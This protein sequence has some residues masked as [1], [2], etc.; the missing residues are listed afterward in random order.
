MVMGKH[1]GN[2]YENKIY[3]ELRNL[4]PDIKLTIGSG[5]SERDADLISDKYVIEIKHYKKLSE[6]QIEDF[7]AKVYGEAVE[8][9]KL[10]ILL[11]KENYKDAK[12]MMHATI[13]DYTLPCTISYKSFK[14]IIK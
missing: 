4:I 9:D 10:P 7:F 2:A 1:K 5:N 14:E 3:K 12:V 11:Y 6:K 8:H 13:G